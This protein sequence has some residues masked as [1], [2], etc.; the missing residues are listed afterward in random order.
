MESAKLELVLKE[1][2]LSPQQLAQP[3]PPGNPP[4]AP[5]PSAFILPQSQTDE[6][7]QK[8]DIYK[9]G[10]TAELP[11]DAQSFQEEISRLQRQLAEASLKTYDPDVMQGIMRQFM[12]EKARIEQETQEANQRRREAIDKYLA[13]QIPYVLLADPDMQA[14]LDAK[15]EEEIDKG[16]RLVQER[17]QARQK[18]FLDYFKGQIPTVEAV[19]PTVRQVQKD[20]DTER[21]RKEEAE[22]YQRV[23]KEMD[24][25]YGK[26]EEKGQFNQVAGLVAQLAGRGNIP[27]VG[28]TATLASS[29]GAGGGIAGAAGPAAAAIAIAEEIKN[30]IV[31][32]IKGIGD[33][34]STITSI[35]ADRFAMGLNDMARKIPVVGEYLGAMG[36]ALGGVIRSLDETAH[37]LAQYSGPLAAQEALIE[38]RN[39]VRD[40]RRAE[41]L[42]DDLAK[43]L[44]QRQNVREKLEDIMTRLSVKLIPLVTSLLEIAENNMPVLE[45]MIEL[46]GIIANNTTGFI[47]ATTGGALQITA[48]LQRLYDA[49]KQPV[50]DPPDWLDK[51]QLSGTLPPAPMPNLPVLTPPG[52][53]G[54]S[55][56]P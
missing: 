12:V 21:M 54:T 14:A 7:R 46:L 8:R 17:T 36:D 10:A 55:P 44:E 11:T 6:I 27:L 41:V 26:E 29:L 42:G 20:M 23:R 16:K 1:E 9:A 5:V 31:N 43:Y 15:L 52:L 13:D 32:V 53:P 51:L 37:R 3:V 49:T 34:L 40:I 18:A 33:T 50:G 25:E 30:Q 22:E 24:P 2:K 47:G 38:V 28:Q 19:D 48:A 4:A 35:D 45:A 56:V 39:I